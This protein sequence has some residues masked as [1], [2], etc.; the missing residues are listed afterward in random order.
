MTQASATKAGDMP[1]GPDTP[2]GPDMLPDARHQA[3]RN[4]HVRGPQGLSAALAVLREEAE[5][6]GELFRTFDAPDGRPLIDGALDLLHAASGR[7]IVT[8]M[9][10]SG[11]IARKIAATLASTGAPAFYVHPA[12]ASHASS[13]RGPSQGRAV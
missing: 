5:A 13:R 1:R 3:T 12:E 6:L 2:R 9:G 8:G 11:H 4:G 10:K 7:V